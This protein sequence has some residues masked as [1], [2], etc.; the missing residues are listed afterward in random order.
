MTARCPT[1]CPWA[2]IPGVPFEE[3]ETC[4]IERPLGQGDGW[5]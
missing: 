5:R 3:C 2:Q 1:G 4:G